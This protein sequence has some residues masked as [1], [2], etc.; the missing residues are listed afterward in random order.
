[1]TKE[2][3]NNAH[4]GAL[5]FVPHPNLRALWA[6][7]PHAFTSA[8]SRPIDKAVSIPIGRVASVRPMPA[9]RSAARAASA[10]SHTAERQKA[11]SALPLRLTRVKPTI[12]RYS[13]SVG[14]NRLYR[15]PTK[16]R[17]STRWRA[18][19]AQSHVVRR[20]YS[21]HPC[22]GTR[23]DGSD[24]RGLLSPTRL[25]ND[26]SNTTQPTSVLNGP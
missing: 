13:H 2:P 6:F 11:A 18:R 3:Q 9:G 4:T 26:T 19:I 20:K 22:V 21:R 17:P 23:K 10:G 16:Q 1:M 5:G 12:V 25:G 24:L 14:R 8:P 7:P 15:V